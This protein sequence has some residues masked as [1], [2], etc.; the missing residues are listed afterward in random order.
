[1]TTSQTYLRFNNEAQEIF[2]AWFMDNQRK[3]ED[4]DLHPAISSHLAKYRS[5][6]PSLALIFHLVEWADNGGGAVEPVSADA[7]LMAAA[8]CQYLES[9][10]RRLY[11]LALDSITPAAAALA[12]KIEAGKLE[13]PFAV[14]MVQRKGWGRLTDVEVIREALTLLE[15]KHWVRE[16]PSPSRAGAGRPADS[17][18]AIN[19]NLINHNNI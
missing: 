4:E 6:M 2:E 9:H 16:L 15:D 13:S 14:R 19:P 7:T 1:M 12:K 17:Q 10:A 8:W 11:A 18:Y 5:L 3:I